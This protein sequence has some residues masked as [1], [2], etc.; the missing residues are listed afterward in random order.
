MFLSLFALSAAAFGAQDAPDRSGEAVF[1]E[2]L[3]SVAARTNVRYVVVRSVQFDPEETVGYDGNLSIIRRGKG[4]FRFDF[5]SYWGDAFSVVMNA[6]KT[7]TDVSGEFEDSIQVT[8]KVKTVR[9]A[10]GMVNGESMAGK[11]GLML[12]GEAS[13]ATFVEE[14]SS[15]VS[16]P[17]GLSR[18]LVT[19]KERGDSTEVL[20]RRLGSA[21]V[22]EQ[23]VSRHKVMPGDEFS[24]EAAYA[25]ED[26]FTE[27]LPVL[28]NWAF[29][30]GGKVPA[31][32]AARSWFLG[33]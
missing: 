15:V 16:R 4:E 1:K 33:R 32:A 28:P 30:V 12:D 23:L 25:R 10:L 24:F 29:S 7:R 17:Y 8:D 11:F 18:V 6:G 27:D 26:V 3:K 14:K 21:W 2:I 19:I 31:G 22:V 5:A 20:A 13:F 9:E